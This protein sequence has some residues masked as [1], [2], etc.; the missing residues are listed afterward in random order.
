MPSLADALRMLKD[1]AD[2]TPTPQWVRVVGGWNEF[3][4]AEKRLPT[5]DELNKAI[6]TGYSTVYHER[7]S[8]VFNNLEQEARGIKWNEQWWDDSKKE[9]MDEEAFLYFKEYDALRNLWQEL[10]V[11]MLEAPSDNA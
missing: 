1:Q 6:V 10:V 11:N 7:A 3:Q 4:F 5:L 8:N 9:L 2:R